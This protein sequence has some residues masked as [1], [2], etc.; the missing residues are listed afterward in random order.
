MSLKNFL[1]SSILIP[2]ISG[3]T[4]LM[5]P[6]SN[7]GDLFFI[8]A[9]F[10]EDE[11][12]SKF[13]GEC[14]MGTYDFLHSPLMILFFMLPFMILNENATASIN[15]AQLTEM[16]YNTNEIADFAKDLDTIQ[17]AI[18]RRNQKF[19]STSEVKAWMQTFP[20]APITRELMRIQK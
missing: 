17:H 7:A 8:K 13:G 9:C 12:V 4:F 1:R 10:S 2:L 19:T 6:K 18:A 16:G 14:F 15:T 20:L 5:T 3:S 11:N